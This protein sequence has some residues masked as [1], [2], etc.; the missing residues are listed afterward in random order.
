MDQLLI[1]IAKLGNQGFI[2]L[3]LGGVDIR[4]CQLLAQ[5]ADL[6]AEKVFLIDAR[7][8]AGQAVLQAVIPVVIAHRGDDLLDGLVFLDAGAIKTESL[9]QPAGTGAVTDGD[10]G[11]EK[12]GL[13]PGAV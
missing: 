12:T 10:Q 5:A 9:R 1:V 6:L 4:L 3:A 13:E 7:L 2:A 11:I 8:A